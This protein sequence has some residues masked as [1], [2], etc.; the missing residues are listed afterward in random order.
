MFRL[1]GTL[2]SPYSMEMRALLRYRRIPFAWVQG[3]AAH[4]LAIEK[5]ETP[6]I[7]V[8]E[9]P[10]GTLANDS[11]PLIY[12]LE[13]RFSERSVLPS[14]PGRHFLAFLIEDF[15]DQ[16]LSRAVF[17]YRWLRPSDQERMS[18]WLAFDVFPGAGLDTIDNFAAK[19]RERQVGR[20]AAAGVTPENASLIEDTTRRVLA[21][22]EAHVP[23][24]YFL[25]G[26]RPSLAEFALYGQ[27]SQLG[28]DPTSQSMMREEFPF[29][30]RWLSHI[31][32]LSG[33]EPGQWA[34]SEDP[35]SPQIK[36]ILALIGA[37]YLPYLR[38]NMKAVAA[39]T[40]PFRFEAL[41]FEYTQA[42]PPGNYQVKCLT[43]LR[44]RYASLPD[45]ARAQI[46]PILEDAGCL[47]VLME[48][49]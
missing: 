44:E 47:P 22:L 21:A 10:D 23:N 4:Q 48:S 40:R 9:Y 36:D 35:L 17:S 31:D 24:G 38:E 15:A 18:T 12:D 49:A 43:E 39:D 28:V 41:G 26:Q 16:W 29:A 8:L 3:I 37:V 5:L 13:Q 14:D 25:F 11:T 6:V 45:A 19:F 20:T 30:Y 32:D 1:H 42:Q 46:D 7:P 33:L 2:G 34:A 27:I